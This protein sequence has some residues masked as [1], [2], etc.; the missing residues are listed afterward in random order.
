MGQIFKQFLPKKEKP[1][2]RKKAPIEVL[3][4]GA[5]PEKRIRAQASK[6][7]RPLLS[8][9]P[10]FRPP[11]LHRRLLSVPGH[12]FECAKIR[13]ADQLWARQK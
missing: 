10:P 7:K 11:P 4:A 3:V 9:A 12:S 6:P 5:P 1:S 2:V 13:A 8:M